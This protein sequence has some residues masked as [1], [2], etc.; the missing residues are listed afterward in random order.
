MAHRKLIARKSMGGRVPRH[1]LVVSVSRCHNTFLSEYGLLTLLW[2]V[3][4]ALSYPEGDEPRY[5]WEGRPRSGGE[6]IWVTIVVKPRA[7]N[8]V[9][10][11]W[12]FGSSG[13]TPREGADR[14]AYKILQ[15][16]LDRFPGRLLPPCLE[17][18]LG[19]IFSTLSGTS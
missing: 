5:F 7:D 12:H 19:V 16:L 10:C 3:L 18:F 1:Q 14:A 6:G 17:S 13:R 11:G 9:M 2:R 8:P 15:D 4:F